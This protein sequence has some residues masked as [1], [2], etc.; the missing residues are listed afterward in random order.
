MIGVQT[1][2]L[3]VED[4]E[5][6]LST[7][8]RADRTPRTIH[9]DQ[10]VTSTEIRSLLPAARIGP[11]R[12]L[13]RAADLGSLHG[14]TQHHRHS[15]LEVCHDGVNRP[16]SAVRIS[17]DNLVAHEKILDGSAPVDG[18]YHGTSYVKTS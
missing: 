9:I 16:L 1:V 11:E 2:H 10:D 8:D 17:G 5:R 6:A 13:R 4:G 18:E 12:M 3:D 14:K 7:D 15:M